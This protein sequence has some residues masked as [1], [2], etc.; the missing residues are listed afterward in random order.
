MAF[1]ILI[2]LSLS[3]FNIVAIQCLEQVFD[4]ESYDNNK[5]ESMKVDKTLQEIFDAYVKESMPEKVCVKGIVGYW[6]IF[7]C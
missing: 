4:V 6:L 3:L 2:L 7:N 5:K 1:L